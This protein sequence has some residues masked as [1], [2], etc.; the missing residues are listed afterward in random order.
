MYF[1]ILKKDLKRKKS[2]NLI[3][4]IFIVLCTTFLAGSVNNMVTTERALDYFMTLI[5][6]C[7]YIAVTMDDDR[8][9]DW[10]NEQPQ[11]DGYEK[12]T[13]IIISPG[14][15]TSSGTEY[16]TNG[17]SC[18]IK[19]PQTYNYILNSDETVLPPL[20]AGEIAIPSNDAQNNDLTVGDTLT[21]R[22][23]TIEKD[24]TVAYITKD[25]GFGTSYLGV[26]RFVINDTDYESL[27]SEESLFYNNY[28]IKSDDPLSLEKA[29]NK[30]NFRLVAQFDSALLKECYLLDMMI[31][32]VLIIVSVCLII[33]ALII[34]RFT[35]S[36]TLQEDYR[37]IGI[38]KA[39]GLKNAGIKR[40]YV[41]KYLGIASI[42][43]LFGVILSV[44]F[45]NLMMKDLRNN[46]AMESS[47]Q[48]VLVNILF[49]IL[50]ILLVV[51]FCYIS[52]GKL[53]KFSAMQAIRSGSRGERYKNKG[54]YQVHRHHRTALVLQMAINDILSNIKSYI[55]LVITFIIGTLLIILPLNTLNT[56]KSDDII[57]Y[58]GVGPEDIFISEYHEDRYYEMNNSDEIIKDL[59]ALEDHYRDNGVDLT[60]HAEL[61]FISTIYADDPED[62]YNIAAYQGLNYTADHYQCYLEGTPPVLKNEVA[63]TEKTMAKLD[64]TIGDSVNIT[65]GNDSKEY[66]ITASYES[67]MNL[68]AGIRFSSTAEL[69]FEYLSAV[70]AIQG[71]ST[72][73]ED[74]PGQI[75]RLK[76]I[77]PEVTIKNPQEYVNQYLSGTIDAMESMKILLLVVV[78]FINCLITALLV[79][80][81]ITKEAGEIALLKNIGFNNR[82]L[83][84][85]QLLRILM[86]LAASILLG[87]L[88]SYPLNTVV[89]KLTFGMMGASNI[90][91][92]IL[93]G[94]VY[95]LYPAIL[96]AGTGIAAL[97]S[98]RR[99]RKIDF[100]DIGNVE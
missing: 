33:M 96:F 63:M 74:I 90:K 67:M 93:I 80:T 22:Q 78:M 14:N 77:T 13:G 85:W 26:T 62:V 81:F 61:A 40:L 55:V 1:H 38:M 58:F 89:V 72:D 44:P 82:G 8:F 31:S 87:I 53:N 9:D 60:L 28:M 4:F 29:L 68:G 64:V 39:I 71:H 84:L 49:G 6:S 15:M 75:A 16:Q 11:V 47:G 3:L 20:K 59:E 45:G 5:H 94:E 66:V 35:I 24:F 57:N 23:G 34:L 42:G 86:V 17:T 37:E 73:R 54:L 25:M 21:I 56:L 43:A 70:I 97:I 7:D 48:N 46:I 88:L 76:V 19:A 83:R 79:R 50:V 18:L 99:I 52:A 95:L 51:L 12:N 27:V 98:T 30:E 91:E 100:S 92:H 32:A 36:F 69:D 2:M 65:I 41:I 10:L